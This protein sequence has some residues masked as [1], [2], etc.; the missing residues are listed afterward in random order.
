MRAQ[1]D[2]GAST[3]AVSFRTPA[4]AF[5][6]ALLVTLAAPTASAQGIVVLYAF[7]TSAASPAAGLT[8]DQRGNFYGTTVFGGDLGCDL[9]GNPGCGTVYKFQNLESFTVLYQFNGLTGPFA[10]LPGPVTI[11][12]D[13]SLYGTDYLG[14]TF[15]DGFV[16]SLRPSLTPPRSTL[17]FWTLHSIHQFTGG[18]DGGGPAHAAPLVFGA[19]GNLYGAAG[20]GL[21]GAGVI[22]EL[23]RSG[24]SWTENVLYNFTGGSDGSEP[25]GIIFDNE[26]NMFGTAAAGANQQCQFGS[27]CGAIFK[28]TH[29]Q[30]GWTE[31]TLHTFQEG[32]EGG[33]SGPLYRDPAGNMFGL[34]NDSGPDNG[35]GTLWELSPN[36]GSWSFSVLH[37]F[38]NTLVGYYGP[39]A[40]TMDSAGN[41]YGVVNWGG[42]NNTGF[43]FEASPS[44]GGWAFTDLFDFEPR[45]ERSVGCYPNGTP[46]LDSGGNIYGVTQLCG[47]IG[48]GTIWEF[49]R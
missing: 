10:T 15:H 18:N 29:T 12:A 35:G 28:L 33:H 40:P 21:N 19:D 41:L 27:G 6:V 13:G 11:A 39:F 4:C 17:A 26:G 16:Y 37:A 32:T 31:T 30:S 36:N 44:G 14:G 34:N 24:N 38:P 25:T 8:V 46:V 5:V 2:P 7:D 9:G 49:T 20:G 43:L 48:W 22:F 1:R 42:G 3:I 45:G 23:T 47:S